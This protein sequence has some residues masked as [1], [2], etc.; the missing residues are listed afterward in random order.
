[1]TKK[2]DEFREFVV[3]GLHVFGYGC[4]AL[5]VIS[6]VFVSPVWGGLIGEC[7]AYHYGGCDFIEYENQATIFL[8]AIVTSSSCIGTGFVFLGL[9]MTLK[10]IDKWAR[11]AE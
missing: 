1:M 7:F 8:V 10:Q 9:G 4:W 6:I 11:G 3:A 5:A 2:R